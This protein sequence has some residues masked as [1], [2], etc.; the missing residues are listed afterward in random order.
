VGESG[1]ARADTIHP[2]AVNSAGP[3]AR[4]YIP[5]DPTRPSAAEARLTIEIRC[6][7]GQVYRADPAHAGRGIRCRCGRT[8]PIPAP[9]SAGPGSAT[10]PRSK[11]RVRIRK[12]RGLDP[13][14]RP[15]EPREPPRPKEPPRPRE[16]P[17]PRE[18]PGPKG[19]ARA[20]A[21][22]RRI[23]LPA[24][25]PRLLPRLAWA[26]L[27][28][29]L[30]AAAFM[31]T[32]GDAWW[33]ASVILFGPRW[34][35]LVPALPLA[36]GALLLRPRLLLPIALGLIVTLGPV[37]GF[38]TGWRRWLAGAPPRTLRI[39]TFNVDGGQNPRV[40]EVP[41]VL[42][43][44]S[45]DVVVLEE[46]LPKLA[47][48]E[49]WPAGWTAGFFRGGLC[50][51]TRL[52]V[53]GSEELERVAVGTQGGTGNAVL[54]RLLAGPDTIAIAGIHLETPRK[55]LESLRYGASADRMPANIL[56]RDVGAGRVSRWILGSAPNPIIAGDFNMPV[57]SRIYRA[58]FGSCTNAFST[59][60][61][62][63]GWTRVLHRFSARIDHVLSCGGGWRP[64]HVEVGPATGSDHR[65]VIVDLARTRTEGTPP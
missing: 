58:Y 37:M 22:A 16:T 9:P 25:L 23:P 39:I 2:A 20:H 55:G 29:A 1:N 27:I 14:D 48:S 30:A 24:W 18:P 26:Y 43:A 56:I 17:R 61:T 52:P 12:T 4:R 31:W 41:V 7:C 34:L 63:F 33:P 8:V 42:A 32:L 13:D 46:C 59:V 36:A 21:R 35:L 19:A 60:G 6:S 3:G 53:V 28:T 50:V 11:I 51:A 49:F 15:A 65:P 44:W 38:R 10:A 64:L 40:G 45:P 5:G 47:R 62:G 57:E 54:V